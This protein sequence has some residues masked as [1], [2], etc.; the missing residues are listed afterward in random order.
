MTSKDVRPSLGLARLPDAARYSLAGLCH[1]A[2]HEAAFRQELLGAVVLTSL[3]IV[4]PVGLLEKLLLVLSMLFVLVVELLNSAIEA[5]VD[6]ISTERHPLSGQA[7]DLGSA[8]VAI[9]LLMSALSWLAI[10]GPV[11]VTWLHALPAP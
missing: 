4:L 5:T 9:A 11:L 2:R 3:A 8:A 10:A 1:A 6:R 7:K